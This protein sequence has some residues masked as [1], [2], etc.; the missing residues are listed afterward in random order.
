MSS[1]GIWIYLICILTNFTKKQNETK[2]G[3][4]NGK[5]RSVGLMSRV[6]RDFG[7]G[8]AAAK[9]VLPYT[10]YIDAVKHLV[11]ARL[12]A[13]DYRVVRDYGPCANFVD[14]RFVVQ[15]R[16]LSFLILLDELDKKELFDKIVNK[17]L[18]MRTELVMVNLAKFMKCT[19]GLMKC[20]PPL[21]LFKQIH[22]ATKTKGKSLL[23]ARLELGLTSLCDNI[24]R[25]EKIGK[26]GF[27]VVKNCGPIFNEEQQMLSWSSQ[28]AA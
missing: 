12:V 20:A 2:N 21:A 28:T 9:V 16:Q 11:S 1:S 22:D 7:D 17:A 4:T 14:D 27:S 3:P 10:T 6:A 19:P 18:R 24:M 5:L 25:I 8:G 23:I 26:S 13:V 15:C